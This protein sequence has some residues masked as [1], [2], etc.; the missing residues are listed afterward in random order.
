MNCR[1]A[2]FLFLEGNTINQLVNLEVLD[3]TENYMLREDD[4]SIKNIKA[5]HL[6]HKKSIKF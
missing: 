5:L 6:K 1:D 2:S 3:I 4:E